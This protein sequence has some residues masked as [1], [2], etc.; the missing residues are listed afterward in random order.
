[1]SLEEQLIRAYGLMSL[2]EKG[3]SDAESAPLE[4]HGP[5]EVRLLRPTSGSSTTTFIF[6]IELYDHDRQLPTDSG[7][8]T[9]FE[10]A[11]TIA[12]H[13]ASRARERNTK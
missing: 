5:Y 10:E 6:W 8:A 11:L 12:K 3:L 13:L 4:Q 2:V 7:G 1:M 9:S